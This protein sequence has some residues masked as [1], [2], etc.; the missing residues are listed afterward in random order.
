[1]NIQAYLGDV[2][3]IPEETNVTING[4]DIMMNFPAPGIYHVN[5]TAHDPTDYAQYVIYPVT[6]YYGV[7]PASLTAA[8]SDFVYAGSVSVIPPEPNKFSYLVNLLGESTNVEFMPHLSPGASIVGFYSDQGLTV[9]EIS[10][11]YVVYGL[12]S[13]QSKDLFCTVSDA[14]GNLITYTFTIYQF[15]LIP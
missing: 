6:V 4:P 8:N 2:D 9:N 3:V 7:S 13:G 11:H 12:S 15:M 1:M 10:D 5:V 14:S